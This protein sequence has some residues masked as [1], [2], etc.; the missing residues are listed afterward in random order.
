VFLRV[1]QAL[2]QA[3]DEREAFLLRELQVMLLE[4][5]L[6]GFGKDT[7]IV[8]ARNAWPEYEKLHVYACQ[9]GRPFQQV[10]P[11]RVL[12]SRC[13]PSD[14]HSEESWLV[15]GCR[16]CKSHCARYATIP[17]DRQGSKTK[18]A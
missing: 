15:R 2:D 1:M 14:L 10:K 5:G 8:A 18:V 12:K 6:L 11:L 7:V 4:E 16:T 3:I 9:P 17:C 13:I